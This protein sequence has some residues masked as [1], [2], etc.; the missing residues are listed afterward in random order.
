MISSFHPDIICH[1][2]AVVYLPAYSIQGYSKKSLVIMVACGDRE[3]FLQFLRL[4]PDLRP[5]TRRRNCRREPCRGSA[6][7]R[8]RLLI[9]PAMLFACQSK[10]G[11]YLPELPLR[12]RHSDRNE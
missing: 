11:E 8:M 5:G 4:V 2:S 9:S 6:S 1:T 12:P 10:S 7:A 3:V